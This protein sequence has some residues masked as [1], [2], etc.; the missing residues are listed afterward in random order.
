[1]FHV[2]CPSINISHK[3]K[4]AYEYLNS[5]KKEMKKLHFQRDKKQTINKSTADSR[6]TCPA[7]LHYLD[8]LEILSLYSAR[9]QE[10]NLLK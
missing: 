5:Y 3:T 4:S 6:L 1:M 9:Q 8:T 7:N 10:I 2:R